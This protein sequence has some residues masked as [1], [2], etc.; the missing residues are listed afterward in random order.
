M[1]RRG[2]FPGIGSIEEALAALVLFA[3]IGA[4]AYWWFTTD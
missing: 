3:L 1:I 2:G 4:V